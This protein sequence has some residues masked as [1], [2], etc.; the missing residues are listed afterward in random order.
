M[1]HTFAIIL[2]LIF[3]LVGILLVPLGLPGTW[4]IA[5]AGVLYSF[6]FSFEDGASSA[7]W[8]NGWL[9]GLAIFGEVMEFLVG[10]LGGKVVNV[11]NGAIISAFV[12]GFVGLFVGVP[13]FL[14]GSL[15]GLFLGAFLGAFIYE[16]IVLKT[17]G[18]AFLTACTVLTTRLVASFLKTVL[19]IG[20]GIFLAM[21]IF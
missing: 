14:V 11:S 8:V 16:L 4:V 1:L 7:I 6:F 17:F 15:I 12:G 18:Q 5:G 9:I 21:H 19:A 20:M 10:N 2:V 13:V 3:I